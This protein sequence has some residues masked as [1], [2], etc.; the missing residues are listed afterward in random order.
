MGEIL[1]AQ[2]FIFQKGFFMDWE[3]IYKYEKI[4]AQTLIRII[5]LDLLH[6]L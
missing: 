2:F 3:R 4:W 6:K 1:Y 5:K